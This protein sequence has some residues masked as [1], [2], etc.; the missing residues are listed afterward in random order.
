MTAVKI[1]LITVSLLVFN[2]VLTNY[3]VPYPS[4]Y[5]LGYNTRVPYAWLL[6]P[7]AEYETVE[8]WYNFAYEKCC[9]VFT[10]SGKSYEAL[11]PSPVDIVY[12][13]VNGSDPRQQEGQ[14]L[15]F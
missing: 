2:I 1:I 7:F 14:F 3:L 5:S 11:W 6:T 9:G 10:L 8:S 4:A 12:T 13:W 15:G